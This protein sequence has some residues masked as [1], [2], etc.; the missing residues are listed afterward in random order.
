MRTSILTFHD[1]INHGAYLQVYALHNFL[2]EMGYENSIINYKNFKHWYN[3]YKCFLYTKNP[4]KLISNIIKIIKFKQNHK[5]LNRT[6]FT[7][8]R[9]R[10]ANIKFDIIIIGS[11]EVWN[12]KIPLFGFD[13][14]YFGKELNAK[15]IISYAPSFGTINTDDD[16]PQEVYEGIKN[17]D[18]IS[19]RDENS[20]EIIRNIINKDVP[21]VVDPIFLYDFFEEEIPCPYSDFILFYG[22]VPEDD[23]IQKI[24]GFAKSQGKK[25][26]SVAYS[27]PW[28][29]IN[30]VALDPFVWLGY[31]KKADLVITSAFHGILF[32]IKYNKE[33]CVITDPY[34]K[35]KIG[36]FLV[37]LCLSQRSLSQNSDLEH[38]FGR[39]I[40]YKMVNEKLNNL[41]LQSKKYLIDSISEL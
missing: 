38:I 41:I 19:V 14:I 34:R 28:C 6:K 25:I 23:E 27:N 39:R 10:V 26:I 18:A 33:F 17:L 24:R 2:K 31:F 21:I 13:P 36:N 32:S 29:D 7:F 5:K 4:K 30:V 9:R 20:K 3:E 8:S 1:G 11:D 22:R 35:N 15:K 37:N 12:F 16:I 40:D